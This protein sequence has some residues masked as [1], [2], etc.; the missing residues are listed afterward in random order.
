MPE[1]GGKISLLPE[2]RRRLEI[3][4]PGENRPIH[5]GLGVI[6]LVVFVFAG[7]KLYNSYLTNQLTGI[8]NEINLTEKQRD[9]EFEREVIRLSKQF[10]LVGSLLQNHL[11]WSNVLIGTQGLLPPQ[12]QIKTLLGSTNEAKLEF[13]GRA[14]NYTTIAKQIAA[15][16]SDKSVADV[17]LDKVSTF[18]S[19]VL[20]YNMRV[21]FDK[22]NFLLNKTDTTKK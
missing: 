15:L 2:S 16:L 5:F 13:S 17:S 20:E 18:S 21:F 4:I 19:G 11:I 12:T 9:K 10:S 8:E 1:Q 3:S 7:V 6:F 22:N 14:V